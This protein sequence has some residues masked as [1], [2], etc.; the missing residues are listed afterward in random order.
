VAP[1]G[2][3]TRPTSDRV[4]EA[5][6]SILFSLGDVQGLRAIDLFAGSGALGIEALSR[7][8]QLATFVDADAPAVAAIETNLRACGFTERATVLRDD[9]DHFL[10][11]TNERFDLAFVDPPYAFD[12]WGSLLSRLP[13]DL[14][15]LESDREIDV[16]PSWQAVRCRRYGSTVVT[17]ARTAAQEHP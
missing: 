7:D 12:D 17:I 5:I 4:R 14:A 3:D 1:D 6:F 15:V 11:S 2:G 8:A 10:R 13:A 16:G 9:V